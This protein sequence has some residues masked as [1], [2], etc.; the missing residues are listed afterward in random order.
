MKA[1]LKFCDECKEERVIWKNDAGNRYCK[2]CWSK[3]QAMTASKGVAKIPLKTNRKSKPIPKRSVK[4]AKQEREYSKLRLT[5]L[6]SSPTCQAQLPNRCTGNSTDV[7]HKAGRI[8]SLLTDTDHWLSVCRGCHDWIE[9]HPKEAKAL[10]F[11][12]NRLNL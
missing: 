10:G 3:K 9:L 12:I 4:R 6:L 1:K 2:F 5:F 11:S 7:H 8:G